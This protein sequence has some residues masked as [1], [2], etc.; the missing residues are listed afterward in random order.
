MMDLHFKLSKMTIV[1]H[2]AGGFSLFFLYFLYIF[3]FKSS[4]NIKPK[5]KK[6]LSSGSS[7][8]YKNEENAFLHL[9]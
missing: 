7:E 5:M 1:K 6:N 8:I 9:G 3:I 4:E 2:W